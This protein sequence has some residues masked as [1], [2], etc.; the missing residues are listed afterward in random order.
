MA[1]NNS[2]IEVSKEEFDEV[3]NH[4]HK[5]I[6]ADFFAEWCMPCLML[7]PVIEEL[8]EQMKDVKFMKINVDDNEELSKKYE[9]SSIPCIVFI[10]NGVEVDRIIGGQSAEAIEEK[11]KSHL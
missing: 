11:I 1:E 2:N 10:K 3:L 6:V 4:P 8:S 7:A 9:I 5:L